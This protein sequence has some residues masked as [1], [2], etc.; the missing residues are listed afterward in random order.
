VIRQKVKDRFST[1]TP[2]ENIYTIPNILTVSR[3][4]A[5]PAIGYLVLHDQHAWAVGL[6]AYAGITDLIDGWVARRWNLQTVV[7]SVID[8]MAD[9]FLMTVLVGCLAVKGALPRKYMDLIHPQFVKGAA[10]SLTQ[11]Q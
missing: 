6:F 10:Q 3:L 8:P 9:K 1:L 4:I 7:G 2:H 11:A 5:T